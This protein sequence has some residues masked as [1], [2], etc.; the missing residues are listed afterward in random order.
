MAYSQLVKC[1]PTRYYKEKETSTLFGVFTA[2]KNAKCFVP[3]RAELMAIILITQ[4]RP[5]TTDTLQSPSFLLL[6]REL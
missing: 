2:K 5:I 1:A 3:L 4:Y 6:T